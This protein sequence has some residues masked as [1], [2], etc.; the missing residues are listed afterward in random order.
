MHAHGTGS[1]NINNGVITATAA[2][3]GTVTAEIPVGLGQTLMCHYTVPAG[4][5]G[6]ITG[7][8]C[9]VNKNGGSSPSVDIA[10]YE[11]LWSGN[12]TTNGDGRFL[13]GY[14]GVRTG[15]GAALKV[16]K[17]YKYISE[18]SDV[19]LRAG[20]VAGTTPDV[21]ASFDIILVDK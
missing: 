10:L 17:P 1:D 12:T 9:T 3:D 7:I 11:H 2:T 13:H 14:W 18:Y 6:Y 8:D 15:Q 19:W 16:Y 5:D 4:K 20:A 21:S